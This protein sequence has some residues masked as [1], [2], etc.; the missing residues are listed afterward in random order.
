[1]TKSELKKYFKKNRIDLTDEVVCGV[2]ISSTKCGYCF[3]KNNE[4]IDFGY[5]IFDND[6]TMYHRYKEFNENILPKLKENNID[7]VVMEDRLKSASN[8]TT[9]QTLFKLS[10]VNAVAECIVKNL[11]G[12]DKV[13]KLHPSTAR[14]LALGKPW[15]KDKD[16][17]KWIIE[18]TM[19]IYGL[20]RGKE[21]PVNPRSTSKP[22][23]YEKWVED[24][25]DSIVLAR[26]IFMV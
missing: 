10:F 19:E 17:K 3:L 2:D 14:S 22:K 11:L 7:F 26:S 23:K 13:F 4:I 9:A 20:E 16:T 1:M 24:V 8:R 21:F 18:S 15:V 25:A 12:E 5:H 6:K